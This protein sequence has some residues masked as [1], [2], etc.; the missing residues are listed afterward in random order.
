MLSITWGALLAR[1]SHTASIISLPFSRP[2]SSWYVPVSIK[3]AFFSS[4]ADAFALSW[5][6][7][8][9]AMKLTSKS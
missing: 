7:S 2:A 8:S 1:S 4:I 9:F 5:V 6:A 3:S